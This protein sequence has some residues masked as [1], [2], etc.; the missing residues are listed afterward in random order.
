MS[1]LDRI[2]GMASRPLGKPGCN[3]RK[4]EQQYGAVPFR[5][6]GGKIEFL[7]IT[8]R[9]TGRWIF[10]KGDPIQGLSPIETAAVE[11]FEEAGVRGRVG[12]APVG[13]YHSVRTRGGAR[14]VVMIEM[15]PLDVTRQFKD[16]P[17]KRER[18]R[19]WATLAEAR[20]LLSESGLVALAEKIAGSARD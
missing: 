3:H 6:A 4:P 11:A 5:H 2:G 7:M 17:E 18:K 1:K 9:R 8:S 13:C 12:S 10:P 14:T 19:R 15:F 20:R 16:W